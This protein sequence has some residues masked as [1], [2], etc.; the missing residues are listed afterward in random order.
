MWIVSQDYFHKFS[1]SNSAL[2]KLK[3]MAQGVWSYAG[4]TESDLCMH[5]ERSGELSSWPAKFGARF[6]IC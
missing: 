3:V 6:M 1:A 4:L 2:N 5:I